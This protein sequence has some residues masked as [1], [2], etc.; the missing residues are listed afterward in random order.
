MIHNIIYSAY[1]GT[2]ALVML[3]VCCDISLLVY[4]I[5]YYNNYIMILIYLEY[6]MND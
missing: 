2:E 5:M 4:W 1:Q 3:G 6:A